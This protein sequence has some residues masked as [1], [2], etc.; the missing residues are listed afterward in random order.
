MQ[1]L[2]SVT[3]EDVAI[4]FS[5]E[6]WALLDTSQRKL[7]RDVMLENIN[8]LVSVGYHH[9]KSDVIFHL[10]QGEELWF[11]GRGFFQS[12]SPG[13]ESALKEEM[14]ATW[15][16]SSK[17]TSTIIPV[18]VSHTPEDPFECND[19]GEDFIYSSTLS[20]HLLTHMEKIPCISKQCQ[21]PLSDQSYL[22]QHKQIHT[23][24]KSCEC[25]LCGKAF[26]NC[27]SLRRH[28]M[29]HTGE[30]PYECHICGNAFIQ[31]SDLRK[32]NLTHTG[33][34]PYECHLCGKAFSQSSNLR[35]HERTHTGEQPYECQLCGKAFSKCSALRRHERTHTG[36]KPYECHLCGKSFSQCSALRRHEGTHNGE[37]SM[38]AFSKYSDLR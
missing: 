7:F 26:S 15:N 19:L 8:H 37:K 6:E 16:I 13:R 35:Q 20:Q 34:K 29:T 21:K 36:E 31:S 24:G 17:D 28:E 3:F 1:P 25:H 4:D 32:H 11:E 30:K 27:S 9:S 33:E 14:L 18:Q 23:R 38:N 2:E 5:Q 22:N 10:E 12:H